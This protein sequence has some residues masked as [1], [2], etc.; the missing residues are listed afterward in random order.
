MIKKSI[1]REQ[2]YQDALALSGISWSIVKI[3]CYSF[4][5]EDKVQLL[6]LA[7]MIARVNYILFDGVDAS[8]YILLE[9]DDNISPQKIA[10]IAGELG[11]K[12]RTPNLS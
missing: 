9:K 2:K 7:L 10:E 1:T 5:E 6:H 12:E 11:G 3:V 8:A 4:P